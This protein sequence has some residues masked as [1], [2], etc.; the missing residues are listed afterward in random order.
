MLE[1]IYKAFNTKSKPK[2]EGNEFTPRIK[3]TVLPDENL[4]FNE[5]AKHIHKQLEIKFN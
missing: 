4:G 5:I 1:T 3:S 2:A